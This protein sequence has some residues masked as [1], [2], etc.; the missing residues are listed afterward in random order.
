MTGDGP[1]VTGGEGGDRRARIAATVRGDVQGVGFRWFVVRHAAELRL[2]GWV[3]NAADGTVRLEAEGERD[4][5]A[6]LIALVR[7]GP[8]GAR[9]SACTVA[10]EAPRETE[11][12][13]EVRG[14]F[15]PGD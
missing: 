13:F 3:A 11:S 12:R 14:S 2:V 5:V 1:G 15:H 4:S 8:P 7:D 6:R 10:E 9:V